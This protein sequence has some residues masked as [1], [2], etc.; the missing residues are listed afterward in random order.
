MSSRIMW[1]ENK[2]AGDGLAGPA[3][4]GRVHFSKTGRSLRYGERTFES[5][6][7]AGHKANYV[8][9]ESDEEFWISGCRKDGQD[10][11]YGTNVIIDAD[12]AEEYWTVIRGQPENAGVTS[13]R[14]SGRY[15]R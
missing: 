4:I 3:R 14:A 12:V 6:K 11:L 7:G 13:F 1:I 8:D 5:L 10:A 15:R 2:S 9:V